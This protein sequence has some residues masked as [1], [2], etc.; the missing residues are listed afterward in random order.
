MTPTDQ[1]PEWFASHEQSDKEHFES[2][3]RDMAE[4]KAMLEP[5][6]ETYKTVATLGKWGKIGLGTILLVL[7]IA[8]AVKN[9][10]PK[11]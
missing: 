4:I 5:I 8:V 7:S 11:F 3:G 1:K 2:L 10:W 6:A 9:L